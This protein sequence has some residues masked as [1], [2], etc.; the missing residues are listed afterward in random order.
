MNVYGTYF[1]VE[2]NR[3]D[4]GPD[5]GRILAYFGSRVKNRPLATTTKIYAT[6]NGRMNVYGTYI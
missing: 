4:N 2:L 3:I 6:E 1:E 5:F